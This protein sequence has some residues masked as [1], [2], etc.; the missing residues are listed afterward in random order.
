MGRKNQYATE[1]ERNLAKSR[2]R[3]KGWANDPE[4]KTL[5]L[6]GRP[7]GAKDRTPRAKR[8]DRAIA[9]VIDTFARLGIEV[10]EETHETTLVPF[11]EA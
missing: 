2:G 6:A 11:D 7:K 4:R 5:V 8:M 1:A 10:E 3:A 9:T